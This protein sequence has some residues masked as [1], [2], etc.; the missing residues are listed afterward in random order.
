LTS[1]TGKAASRKAYTPVQL[2]GALVN[3]FMV[4]MV[5]R[6]ADAEYISPRRV[7]R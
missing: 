3:G 1:E 5:V 2:K 4:E 6:I 7:T